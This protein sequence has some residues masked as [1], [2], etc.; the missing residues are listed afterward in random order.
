M[1]QGRLALNSVYVF[2]KYCQFVCAVRDPLK[3]DAAHDHP[4]VSN[5]ANRSVKTNSKF[6]AQTIDYIFGA[7][8]TQM[9]VIYIQ[10]LV[11]LHA[12]AILRIAQCLRQ[13]HLF[14]RRPGR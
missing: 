7:N 2:I 9:I 1:S 3:V 12:I 11:V 10:R 14:H 6:I 8:V 5:E 4:F 13:I